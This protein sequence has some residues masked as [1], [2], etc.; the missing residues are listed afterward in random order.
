MAD[1]FV[2]PS[3][4][5]G[6]TWGLAVNEAMACGRAVLVSDKCGCADDLVQEG[7]NGYVFASRDAEDLSNKIYRMLDKHKLQAMGKVSFDIIR[8]WSYN[9]IIGAIEGVLERKKE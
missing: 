9:E 2:L 5:P 4:G 8:H 3:K 6:E 7:M 1:V